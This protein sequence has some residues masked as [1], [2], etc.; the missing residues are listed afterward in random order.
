MKKKFTLIYLM[1][2]LLGA[3]AYG[4]SS[5]A[6]LAT[7][8]GIPGGSVVVPITVTDFNT[9]GA[10]T[11]KIRF[12][13]GVLSFTGITNSFTGYAPLVGS[14]DTTVSLVWS[15]L[16]PISIVN[17]TLTELNFQYY[18]TSTALNFFGCAVAGGVPPVNVDVS[19]TNGAVSPFQNLANTAQ[20][21][22]KA[23]SA[24]GAIVSVPLYYPVFTENAGSLTQK[25]QYDPAKLSFQ[26][27]TPKGNLIGAIG[28]AT[29]GIVTIAWSDLA[30]VNIGT[31]GD[32]IVLNFIY[33]GP[34][35]AT[36]NFA[37]G[38]VITTTA[39]AN[40]PVTY[41]NGLITAPVANGIAT[42]GSMDACQGEIIE[43]PL[44]FSSF[45]ATV[46]SFS[47]NVVF[48]DPKLSFIE[49]NSVNPVGN[50]TF[51]KT[52]NILS[53][54]WTSLEGADINGTFLNIKFRYNGVGA[55]GID[56]GAGCSFTILP[57]TPVLVSYTNSL[58]TP[59]EV[60]GNDASIG[61]VQATSGTIVFVP[62][63]FS[64]LA[65][66]IGAVTLFADF[67]IANLSFIDASSNPFGALVYATGNTVAVSWASA[68]P[69]NV[70]G[71]F[72]VLRFM[73]NNTGGTGASP[74]T[75]ADGC[76]IAN[77]DHVI[78]CMDYHDGGVNLKFKISGTLK[79]DDGSPYFRN[80]PLANF[81]V[82]L[83]DAM[84]PVVPAT[85]PVPVKL[86][87]VITDANGY[88]E[89]MAL[90]GTYYLYGGQT[91]AWAGVGPPDVT[92][93]RRYIAGLSNTIIGN[94]LRV[95]AV[96]INQ[97]GIIDPSDVTPLRR[98]IANLSPNP[99]YLAPDW[100][101]TNPVVVVFGA[102]VDN[103]N[104][105]GICSGDADGSYPTP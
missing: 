27:I 33:N 58:I 12:T 53:F 88:F 69:T 54:A 21:G 93:I 65:S 92:N 60:V 37:P 8:Q 63:S 62:V 11:M 81:K 48:Q 35:D 5:T 45:P 24:V 83:K 29:G 25:I 95:R 3:I 101:Y 72:V 42:L 102:A 14:T 89:F 22:T 84:E 40:I 105:L 82:Y 73:Y 2:L 76:E 50:L 9:V 96:D 99:N 104:F 64:G 97:D 15:S 100:F 98:R 49:I 19:Y 17:G 71:E 87:S 31:P 70:N 66:D 103:Q 61:F 13:K 67:D 32:T 18:G 20:I 47:L 86:D 55:A 46:S 34:T 10:I 51:N 39:S 26:S 77:V 36:L 68:T 23:A 41:S 44:D 43:V 85:T 94:A 57:S 91:A 16:D 59:V 90:N 38:C 78:Q 7:V 56:F 1:V 79:Y 4:Q 6:S 28:S 80:V 52:G 75:F 30:G 74:I